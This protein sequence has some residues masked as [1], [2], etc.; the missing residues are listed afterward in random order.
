MIHSRYLGNFFDWQMKPRSQPTWRVMHSCIEFKS[1]A[2]FWAVKSKWEMQHVQG[3]ATCIQYSLKRLE[4]FSFSTFA[5]SSSPFLLA[6]SVLE[7][8]WHWNG[9]MWEKKI[10]ERFSLKNRNLL[11]PFPT[12]IFRG[13]SWYLEPFARHWH[14]PPNIWPQAP[15]QVTS[16]K[17]S[18]STVA[19]AIFDTSMLASFFASLY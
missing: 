4:A 1:C 10:P 8:G 17:P 9:R 2:F 12:S 16:V 3:K 7:V 6:P 14:P 13:L 19:W 15:S 5:L 11:L 18:S